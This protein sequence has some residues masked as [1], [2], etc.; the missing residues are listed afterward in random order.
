MHAPASLKSKARATVYFKENQSDRIYYI[1][2]E[3][4]EYEWQQGMRD[5]QQKLRRQLARPILYISISP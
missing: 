1:R 3:A 2:V 4:S 5:E